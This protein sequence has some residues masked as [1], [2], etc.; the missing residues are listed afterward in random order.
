MTNA[1]FDDAAH[2]RYLTR[3]V[4]LMHHAVSGNSLVLLPVPDDEADDRLRPYVGQIIAHVECTFDFTDDAPDL[5]PIMPADAEAFYAAVNDVLST[6]RFGDDTRDV[7]KHASRLFVARQR[8]EQAMHFPRALRSLYEQL[9]PN[10]SL[11]AEKRA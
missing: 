10:K 2:L 3:V 6:I 4:T 11:A 9:P 7:I 8:N 1:P 5:E